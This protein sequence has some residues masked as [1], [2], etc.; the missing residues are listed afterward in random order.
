M[1]AVSFVLNNVAVVEIVMFVLGVHVDMLNL[2]VVVT[3][4]VFEPAGRLANFYQ[5]FN[6]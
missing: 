6:P 5:W 1:V 4:V 2:L 3:S